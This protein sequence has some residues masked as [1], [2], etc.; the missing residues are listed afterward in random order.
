MHFLKRIFVCIHCE[1]KQR[2][3]I[4]RTRTG[5]FLPVEISK[6]KPIP[7]EHDL[8]DH[9]IHKSH[10]LNCKGLQAVWSKK[11]ASF[12]NHEKDLDK[13]IMKQYLR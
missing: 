12:R 8:F 4:V 3:K 13:K 9:R 2:L 6:N 11:T 7:N 5:S 10:L 1:K